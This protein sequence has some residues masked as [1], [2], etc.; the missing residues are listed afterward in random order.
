[1]LPKAHALV[2]VLVGGVL[3]DQSSAFALPVI[4]SLATYLSSD[5][6]DSLMNPD[7]R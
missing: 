2:I 5:I 7:R 3:V 6:F 4:V 1:M